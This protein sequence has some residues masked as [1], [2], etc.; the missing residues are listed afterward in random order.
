MSTYEYEDLT[1]IMPLRDI[2]EEIEG[3]SERQLYA[4]ANS[5]AK[6]SNGFPEPVETLGVYKLY[7]KKA[8]TRWVTLWLKAT[9]GMGRGDQLNAH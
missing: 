1:D 6:V 4:W 7:S 8:V 9:R 5:R 2:A 3:I